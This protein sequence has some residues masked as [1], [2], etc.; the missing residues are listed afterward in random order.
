MTEL[1]IVAKRVINPNQCIASWELPH[2]I[3]EVYDYWMKQQIAKGINFDKLT[4]TKPFKP[5]STGLKSQNH[6][7]NGYCQQVAWE[8][9]ED[10][11]TIKMMFKRGAIAWKYPFDT[12]PEGDPEPWSEKRIDSTQAGYLIEYIKYWCAG[13]NSLDMVIRLREE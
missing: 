1:I 13:N 8:L 2:H 5:R 11:D 6:A 9:G 7:I 12:N 4:I 10:F 3:R